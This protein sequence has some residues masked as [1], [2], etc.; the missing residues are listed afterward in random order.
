MK[1]FVQC[2]DTITLVAPYDVVAGACLKVG[3]IVAVATYSALSGA[4]VEASTEGVFDLAKATGAAWA[5]GDA[6]Y[7]DDS[8]KKVTGTSSGNTKIGVALLAAA[9]GDTVGRVRLNGAF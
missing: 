3:S 1:N 8:A 2:G 9:S 6:L 5:V 7:W 4:A